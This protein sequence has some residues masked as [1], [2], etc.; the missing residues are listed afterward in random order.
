VIAAGVAAVL[1]GAHRSG[2]WWRCR[3]PV[4]GSRGATLSLRDGERGLIVRCW[5]GCD[6]RDALAA[7]RR[8]GLLDGGS[9][10]YRPA[11]VAIRVDARTDDAR[12]IALARRISEAGRGARGSPVVR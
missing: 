1:G 8:R 4:H 2:A 11:P 9:D 12:R 6:P 7:L 10:H 5:A 3:C